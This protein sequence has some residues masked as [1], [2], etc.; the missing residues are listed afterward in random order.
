MQLFIINSNKCDRDFLG[1]KIDICQ[2]LN[3]SVATIERR[4]K[5]ISTSD[6]EK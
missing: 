6:S 4:S 3:E 2:L 5:S 1:K